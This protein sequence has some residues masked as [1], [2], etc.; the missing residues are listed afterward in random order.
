MLSNF[1]AKQWFN[2]TETYLISFYIWIGLQ[3]LLIGTKCASS[4]LPFP[5]NLVFPHPYNLFVSV[6]AK[7]KCYPGWIDLI[8]YGNTFFDIKIGT[9]WAAIIYGYWKF[10]VF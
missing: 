6:N 8:F 2:P 1:K 4:I 3:I 9:L 5:K 7:A 10:I